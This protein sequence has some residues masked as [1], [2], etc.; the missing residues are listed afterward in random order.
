MRK[1]GEEEYAE[2]LDWQFEQ[3]DD[4]Y[5]RGYRM[6]KKIIAEKASEGSHNTPFAV[7]MDIVNNL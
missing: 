2:F 3:R 1:L 5:G 4:E 6:I 7:M